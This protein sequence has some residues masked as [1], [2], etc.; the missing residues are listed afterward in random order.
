MPKI[1]TK[2]GDAGKSGLYSGERLPKHDLRFH[3]LGILD[4]LQVCIGFIIDLIPAES[5]HSRDIQRI[6][7][8]ISSD[9]ATTRAV[10]AKHDKVRQALLET[11]QSAI[12]TLERKIDIYDGQIPKLTKFI[13]IGTSIENSYIHRCRVTT[14]KAERLIVELSEHQEIHTSIMKYI[15]RLSDYFFVIARYYTHI[16]GENE[17]EN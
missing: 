14:R 5:E 15:N 16:H 13:L 10:E 17:I 1:Y 12:K 8:R 9:I 6:L 4:E 7:I 2:T 3:V 11:M